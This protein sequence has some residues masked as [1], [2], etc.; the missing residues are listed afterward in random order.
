MEVLPGKQ[1]G[2]IVGPQLLKKRVARLGLAGYKEEMYAVHAH[3]LFMRAVLESETP[4]EVEDVLES[5]RESTSS[6]REVCDAAVQRNGKLGVPQSLISL[7][8]SR[9]RAPFDA[10]RGLKG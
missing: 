4:Q 9:L 10:I 2:E 1:P 6:K 3:Y 7:L 8:R 5:T